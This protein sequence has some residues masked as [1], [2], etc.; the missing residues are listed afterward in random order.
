VTIEEWTAVIQAVAAVATLLLGA[1]AIYIAVRAL[2]Q[3]AASLQQVSRQ[4]DL[5]ETAS[6]GSFPNVVWMQGMSFGAEHGLLVV[7]ADIAPEPRLSEIRNIELVRHDGTTWV[8]SKYPWLILDLSV[9]EYRLDQP[10]DA[11][12]ERIP[13]LAD[14]RGIGVFFPL[15]T[16]LANELTPGD[17]SPV[18]GSTTNLPPDVDLR[19]A[20]EDARG[21]HRLVVPR[22]TFTFSPDG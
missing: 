15:T 6:F 13:L 1:I 12:S 22:R 10:F 19:I 14:S 18:T 17:W 9:N 21:A 8:T 16:T 2:R 4:I 20:W 5:A 7:V 11:G 3:S